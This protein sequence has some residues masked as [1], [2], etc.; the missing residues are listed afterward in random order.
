MADDE[1]GDKEGG[2]GDGNGDEGGGQATATMMVKKR[3]RVARAMVTRVVGDEEGD[4][5]GGNMVRNNGDGLVPVIV[6]QAVLYS[7]SALSAS[8]NNVGD[9]ELTER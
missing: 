2:K 9:D 3:A 5:D 4:G 6:Q 8:L 1:G 7:T